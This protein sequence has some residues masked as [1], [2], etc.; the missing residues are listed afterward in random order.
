MTAAERLARDQLVWQLFL[1]GVPYR[2]IGRRVNLSC[3]G[4]ELA[5]R[6]QLADT[7]RRRNFMT[8][9]A[10][11]LHNERLEAL[12][13]AAYGKAIEGNMRAQEQCRR[14]LAEMARVRG[15]DAFPGPVPV[16]PPAGDDDDDDDG[17]VDELEAY[18]RRWA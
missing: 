18:R 11:A 16:P 1:A 14:L 10:E 7:A 3:R 2:K 15:V 4:V 9:E 6:R 17:E 5:V 8:E 12:F 13:A